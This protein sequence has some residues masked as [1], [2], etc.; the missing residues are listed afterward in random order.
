MKKI[1]RNKFVK[2]VMI[3]AS[4]TAGAQLVTMLFSPII[5]RLYGPEA[6]GMMGTFMAIVNIIVPVAALTYP[7]A[8]VLAKKDN[9]AR[10]I[11]NLS[12]FL[13]IIIAFISLTIL[14]LFNNQISTIFNIQQ[15]SIYLYFIPFL[16][17]LAAFM[18]VMEQWSIRLNTFNI[19][20]KATFYQS[21]IINVGKTSIGFY[22]P[23]PFVLILF[24]TLSQ[25]LKGFLMYYSIVKKG[26]KTPFKKSTKKNIKVV[27]K[28][29]S[30]FPK[31]R[32]P[33]D[34]LFALQ[35]GFPIVL[36]TILFGPA[37]VGLYT[38]GRTVLNL[39]TIL[40]GKAVSDVF[41]PKIVSALDSQKNV[42]KMLRMATFVLGGVGILPYGLIVLFGPELFSFVFGADWYKAGEY[43]RWISLWSL[44]TLMNRPSIASL[45]ALNAQKFHLLYTI[46]LSVSNIIFMIFG[47]IIFKN[48]LAAV[49]LFCISGTIG[50]IFLISLTYKISKKYNSDL[51]EV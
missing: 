26:I 10:A 33:Q 41:Y 19:N 45:P 2:N 27:A 31:Y 48:D 4:G 47:Y 28:E 49:A 32:A 7:I 34:F 5:T 30:D 37:S 3:V 51:K 6:F 22:Y 18:Q 14:L 39:P 43:A 50:N 15:I 8:I 42:S 36:L 23:F 9:N 44:S 25:G 29:F 16:I 11:V 24:S 46:I 21:I 40:I 35:Q 38:I 20:A 13:S 1:I 17:I 12:I